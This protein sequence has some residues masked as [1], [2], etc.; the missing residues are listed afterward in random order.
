MVQMGQRAV[1]P[2]SHSRLCMRRL[3]PDDA[4]LRVGQVPA[5]GH[6]H[7][8]LEDDAGES[9]PASHDTSLAHFLQ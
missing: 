2:E 4:D 1:I 7:G 8:R 5:Q 3:L 9:I 6:P